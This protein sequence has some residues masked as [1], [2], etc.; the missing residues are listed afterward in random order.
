MIIVKL[1]GSVISDKNVEKSFHEDVV[2]QI[3]SEI[4]QFYPKENFI[5]VHGGGS[6]GHPLAKEYN[7][8]EGIEPNPE[9]KRIGFS[10]THQAML[11]LNEKIINIFLEKNLP[12]FS[13]STSSVFITEGGS[14][15]YGN[16]EVLKRLIELR[17]IPVLFG[18]VAVDLKKG[19]DILSGD[20]I[21][22]YLAK[23]LRPSKVIFLMDV[24]GIYDGK[25]DEGSLIWELKVREIDRLIERLSGSAGI[26]VTGGI[27]NKLRETKEIAQF[28]E[29]WFVNGKVSG[30]LSGAIIGGGTGTKIMP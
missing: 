25:P 9:S 22:T 5:I 6:Y 10:K 30:R 12:A 29:V 4:A 20:Q 28:S 21:I 14:V 19:I 2:S 17:L 13:V 3:A 1:G 16:V 11:E 24:D 15:A 7:L 26:D 23:M 27:A 8:R 18:D